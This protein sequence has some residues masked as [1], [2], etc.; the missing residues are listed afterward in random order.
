VDM[1]KCRNLPCTAEVVV[2]SVVDTACLKD[3]RCTVGAWVAEWVEA[4]EDMVVA[5]VVDLK[6]IS[7]ILMIG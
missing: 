1:D 4:V 7:E 2:D 5:W 6:L 3:P